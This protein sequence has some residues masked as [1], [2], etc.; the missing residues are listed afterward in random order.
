MARLAAPSADPGEELKRLV[1]AC[2]AAG[3]E[4]ILD[5]VLNHTG[6]GNQD[7]VTTSWRGIDAAGFYILGPNGVR[8]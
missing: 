7:G 6:E 4:V 1:R 2:H 5:V 3:L 8:S